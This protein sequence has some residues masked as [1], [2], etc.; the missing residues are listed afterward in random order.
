MAKVFEAIC[1][2]GGP[3]TEH[4]RIVT[5]VIDELND[6][7]GFRPVP[8]LESQ[9]A[10]QDK[11]LPD[12]HE[13][14]A[15]IPLY[16]DGVGVAKGPYEKVVE[17]ALAILKITDPQIL[18]EAC[19]DVA[20]LEE[21]V[22]D[23]RAYD[24][25]HPVNR[26]PNYHFGF[27]DP[28]Y[29]DKEGYYRR[30]V[31]H[32]VTLDGIMRRLETAYTGESNEADIPM[33]ELVFEAG[34][35]LVG[36]ML[37]GSGACG[38]TP[39]TYDS[40]TSLG[41]LM[42]I[43]AHYRDR[44]Y[45]QLIEKAPE[46]MRNRIKREAQRLFQ[47][48]GACRQNLN[49]QLAKQRA[50]QLQRMHLAKIFAR[51]GYFEA[52]TQQSNVIHIV[53][54][55]FLTK[56]D[57]LIT[58][59]HFLID[60]YELTEA[61]SQ[62]PQIEELLHRGIAC[63]AIVDPWTILGFGGNYSLFH[64]VENAIHDHRID[65]LIDLLNVIFALY[66]RLQK[67]AAAMGDM[68]LQA[69]LSDAMSDLAGWWDQFGSTEVSGLESFSGNDI[70]E[71]SA[72]V[73]SSLAI[74]HR[75]GS[76]AGDVAFWNRH[77]DRFQST[78]AYVLLAEALLEQRDLV[79]SMALMMHWLSL[80][81]SLSLVEGDYSFHVLALRWL[82]Q[83]WKPT[84]AESTAVAE[85]DTA[86]PRK[87][88][89]PWPKMSFSER[90]KLTKKFFD[91]IEANAGQY[92]HIPDLEM[93]D[94]HFEERP[95]PD[96]RKRKRRDMETHDENEDI[97]GAYSY[98]GFD[99]FMDADDDLED[100]PRSEAIDPLFGAAYENVTYHDTAND[101]VDDFMMDAK[102]PSF[103]DGDDLEIVAE[104]ERIGDRLAFVVTLCKLWKFTA[105]QI[106]KKHSQGIPPEENQTEI[107]EVT[108]VFE[109]W[110]QQI[111]VYAQGLDTL[112]AKTSAY[113]VPPPRGTEDSLLE[114]DRHRGTKEILLDRIVWTSVELRDTILILKA[115]LGQ[116][117]EETWENSVLRTLYAVFHQGAR[118]ASKFWTP[119]L[120]DLAH[121]QLLYVPTSRGGSAAAI[122]QCRC[123][124]QVVLRLLEYGPRLGLLAESF[125]LLETIK[126]M[127]EENTIQRGAITEF[128]RLVETLTR[129][130]TQCVAKS[131]KTWKPPLSDENV[132]ADTI[133][134]GFLDQLSELLLDSWLSHSHLIR[135]SPV[136][137]LADKNSWNEIKAFIMRYGKD[138]F[139]QQHMGF[140][141][142][143]AMLHQG[144]EN[145]LRALIRVHQQEGEVDFAAMLVEELEN[146][147]A[148]W[149]HAVDCLELIFETIAENYTEF[150]DYNSTS[151]H[152]DHGDKL[153]MLLDM[154]R[155]KANYER[156]SWNLKPVYWVHDALIRSDCAEAAKLWEQSIAK[157]SLAAS[158]QYLDKYE[159]LSSKYGVWIPS[160]HERLQER[161]IGPLRVA[162]MCGLVPKVMNQVGNL[163]PQ[164]LFA[165]LLKMIEEFAL[166]QMGVGYE[167]P[168]WLS[169]LGD[170][171]MV[172]RFDPQMNS[173]TDTDPF[174]STPHFD[175]VCLSINQLKR[176]IDLFNRK[177]TH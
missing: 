118:E 155:V 137:S 130:I 148:E 73:A 74:W 90:W 7:I 154:L 28:E 76:A 81:D 109:S 156:V 68:E 86:S 110:L 169:A 14:V 4:E 40:E 145:F 116:S 176:A 144:V 151:T 167:M 107:Q 160:I 123:V 20:K 102:S 83:L 46:R 89:K 171:V 26:K 164:P 99:E 55:R 64:S 153:Y 94:S 132:S 139:V 149:S 31:V 41:D 70:W 62:L 57:C 78:K 30:F 82:E 163:G 162:Q 36:T 48:F 35:V 112:L 93:D 21:L 138:I 117:S 5:A 104:T 158:Q 13:W 71:S 60:R 105:E 168:E 39:Q 135:I 170:E 115:W 92:G 124:Q 37:M 77:V 97:D 29:I 106:A 2:Q 103:Q 24:F 134:I 126:T 38:D 91:F 120:V 33:D 142:L 54:S 172:T 8:V 146:G 69:D 108:M 161:F 27:W 140:A 173:Y 42:P 119:M 72:K 165:D 113:I 58:Q 111:A 147:R 131:S 87:S 133:L 141:N 52:A 61:A 80:S 49:K 128:D 121:E 18:Y 10:T 17:N 122:V 88:P 65:E 101:G 159:R 143:R 45:E 114:Y 85:S 6:Y 56:I 11:H 25:D 125:R 95:A 67:E 157:R 3:W 47:P 44:F 32:Q 84:S 53:S 150:I 127:E 59:A 16:M 19:F 34:A 136:E 174:G 98:D 96:L 129:A 12:A 22:L 79:A 100:E 66:G 23:P 63:G 43:I 177:K 50:D 175:Q 15:P 1:Q 51:M 9:L 166:D 75:A 152:S